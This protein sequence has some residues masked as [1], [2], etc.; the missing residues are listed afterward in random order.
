MAKA[1][2]GRL[3]GELKSR[4][5]GCRHQSRKNDRHCQR[6]IHHHRTPVADAAAQ[7]AVQQ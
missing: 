4:R 2:S 7:A 5:I 3:N 1:R 6:E